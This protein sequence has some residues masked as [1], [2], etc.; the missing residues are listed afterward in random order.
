M[1][2]EVS[3][4]DDVPKRVSFKLTEKKK[5]C[6]IH[7][8]YVSYVW[9]LGESG[10]DKCLQIADKQRSIE[11]RENDEKER[12]ERIWKDR[13]GRAAIPERFASR[14]LDS[15]IPRCAKSAR[16]L[17]VSTAYASGFDDVAQQGTCLIFCGGVGTGKTHL[18]IG[19][20]NEIIKQGKQPVFVSVIKAIRTIKETYSRE[21]KATEGE[22]IKSFI[23]PDLLILDEVGVQFGSETEKLYLFEIINGRYERMKPTLLI[24]NLSV[25]ELGAFI[26]DRVMDRL[27]EGGGKVVVFDWVSHRKAA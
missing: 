22:A 4:E 2:T 21:A 12:Q 26:G 27:R 18:A 15:Y 17:E 3:D 14:T 6:E 7:G 24:S 5:V 20:A 25:T 16:A 8:E 23:D 10:C 1:M 9:K 11:R 19:I 13:L